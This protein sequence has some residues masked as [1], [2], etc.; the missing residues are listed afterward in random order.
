MYVNLDGAFARTVL[1]INLITQFPSRF[2]LAV[3]C[4][5]AFAAFDF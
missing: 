3:R 5:G 1:L 4:A 2:F